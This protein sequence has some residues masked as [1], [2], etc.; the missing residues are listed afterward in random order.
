MDS[1]GPAVGHFGGK[2]DPNNIA[3]DTTVV[4]ACGDDYLEKIQTEEGLRLFDREL[5]TVLAVPPNGV[6]ECDQSSTD[7]TTGWE[8]DTT[9]GEYLSELI[10]PNPSFLLSH[11]E[12]EHSYNHDL[13]EKPEIIFRDL[14][15]TG[16][17]SPYM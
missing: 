6:T 4:I 14:A 2:F 13:Q 7:F 16:V 5:S 11:P 17:R 8:Y 15:N 3:R 1:V 9:P 12:T 10:Y